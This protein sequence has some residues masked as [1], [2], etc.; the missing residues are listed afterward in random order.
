MD[1]NFRRC[2]AILVCVLSASSAWAGPLTS[3]GA[4]LPAWK[5]TKL[6]SAS[7]GGFNLNVNVDYAVYAP[8]QFSLSA[9][10]GF[11]TD[12]SG[13]ADYV[14]AYQPLNNAPAGTTNLINLSVG[15]NP[16]ANPANV[17]H[18]A[19]LGQVSNVDQFI[20]VGTPKTSARW[21]WTSPLLNPGSNSTVLYF[22]SPLGPQFL[23]S[24]ITGGHATLASAALPSPVP[25]PSTFLLAAIAV[26]CLFGVKLSR[27]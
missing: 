27:P 16:G 22:T 5:G 23:L 2:A 8:G 3:D 7:S 11:P 14:Y 12:P 24:S 13:G 19:G 15:L 10:L 17:G 25:E 21:V 18:L 26:A 9:A 1:K 20:P 4:A 6:F